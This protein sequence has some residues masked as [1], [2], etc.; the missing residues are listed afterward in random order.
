MKSFY[1]S[2]CPHDQKQ[3]FGKEAVQYI[4]YVEC[5]T[6]EGRGQTPQCQQQQ[7][8]G[9]PTWK[10]NGQKLPS[11]TKSLEELVQLSGYQGARNFQNV[12]EEY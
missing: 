8:Q 1:F 12:L 11:G 6:P 2:R 9:Y 3:L 4:T 7:I 5:S 10:I